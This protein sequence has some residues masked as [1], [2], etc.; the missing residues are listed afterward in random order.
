[1]VERLLKIERANKIL[2]KAGGELYAD[3]ILSLKNHKTDEEI[4][5]HLDVKVNHVRSVLN[6]LSE[7]G[8]VEYDRIKDKET[9]W[10]TYEWKINMEKAKQAIIAKLDER[11]TEVEEILNKLDTGAAYIC[12][13]GCRTYEFEEAMEKGFV[14]NMC[15]GT[16]VGGN[17]VIKKRLR[18]EANSIEKD[19]SKIMKIK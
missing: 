4:A 5:E 9:G 15:N 11:K 18:E 3:V 8:A 2:Y 6:K 16:I 19:I 10:F 1:M 17:E 14:C 12:E 7:F 13:N